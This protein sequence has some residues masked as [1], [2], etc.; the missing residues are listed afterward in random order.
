[1]YDKQRWLM[2]PMPDTRTKLLENLARMLVSI[3]AGAWDQ[4]EVSEG[5]SLTRPQSFRFGIQIAKAAFIGLLPIGLFVLAQRSG[6]ITI[7]S[8][9][10]DYIAGGLLLWAALSVVMALDPT[11]TEKTSAMKDVLSIIPGLGKKGEKN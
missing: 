3:L 2:T 10:S 4:L 7:A 11:L 8:P 1:L 9:V 6:I 5:S